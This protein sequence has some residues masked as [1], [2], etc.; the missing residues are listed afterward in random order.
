[1]MG[2]FHHGAGNPGR[3]L[4]KYYLASSLPEL[5]NEF[6]VGKGA[7]PGTRVV[8]AG[9]ATSERLLILASREGHED[10]GRDSVDTCCEWLRL[11]FRNSGHVEPMV[12]L[13]E[14]SSIPAIPSELNSKK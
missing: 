12:N 10:S 8:E 14:P 1:M 13:W 5:G 11:V 3:L 9:S 6:S 2:S 7:E 4:H